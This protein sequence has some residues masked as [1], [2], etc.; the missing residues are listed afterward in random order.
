MQCTKCGR[1]VARSKAKAVTRRT[2][3]VDARVY[4]ELKK[5]GTIIMGGSTKKYYCISCAVH[6]HQVSQRAKNQRK[7]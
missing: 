1:L 2:N 7:G 5:T 6:S 4:G 3:I